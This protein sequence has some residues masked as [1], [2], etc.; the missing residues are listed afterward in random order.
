MSI[1]EKLNAV[2][3]TIPHYWPIGSFI[4]HN[5][6]KGF[7]NLHFKEALE[8]AQDV[9]GG[10]SYMAPEYYISHYNEGKIKPNTLEKNLLKALK[11]AHLE[12]FSSEAKTFMLEV[13]PLW[14]S[15]RSYEELK[16]NDIDEELHTYLEDNSIYS[17]K[18][19]WLDTL[20]H[21]M[22]FYEIH[23]ALFNTTEK[24]LI[25]KDV[26]EYIARFLD[27]NQTTLSMADRERGMFN[28]F[29]LYENINYAGNAESYVEIIL[30]KLKVKD[31]EKYL[32]THLL[33]LYGW[34]G[35]IK[36]RSEDP[37]YYSQQQHPSS[38]IDYIAVKLHFELKYIAGERIDDF[39]K[40]QA[41]IE[42]NYAFTILKLLQSKGRLTGTYNDAMEE[43]Q[44]Y[45]KILDAFV[46]DEINL[47]SL[48]IQLAKKMIPS[49]DMPLIEFSKFAMFIKNEEG[50][51]W[52]KSLED[53]YI[54][55]YV[56]DFTQTHTYNDNPIA[57]AI[58][59][60]DVRSE[61][62]RRKIEQI[63]AYTTFGAGG[64]LGLPINFVPFDKAHELAL[65]PAV[66]KPKNIVFEVPLEEHEEYNTKK[67]LN[68]TYKKVLNDLKNNPYT[69]YIMVEAIG[70]AFG[71]KLF[72]KTF[73]PQKTEKL[74]SKTKPIKPKTTFTLD[75]L[76]D[77]EIE[78][79]VKK[80]HINIIN[81]VLVTQSDAILNNPQ[82]ELL[83]E[84]LVLDKPLSVKVPINFIHSLKDAYHINK[85]DYEIQKEKLSHVGFTFEEQ[86]KYLETILKMMGYTKDFSKFII[87]VAHGSTSDNNPFESALDCGACGGNVS[88]P[89]TRAICM[90][91]NKTK[92]RE[93][94]KQRGINI[95][96]EVRFVP[97][98]HNTTTDEITYYDIY[99]FTNEEQKEFEKVKYDFQRASY[100]AR[101][102]RIKVL[103]N[104]NTQ[105]DI[106]V[107][108]MDWSD[109]RPEWGLSRN[110]GA[111]AGPRD[112]I[113]HLNLK[114]R[115]FMHSYDWKVDNDN[116]DL[117][118][119]IFDGPLIV[120]EWINLTHYFSTVD[121]SIYGAG[122]KVYHN[123]VAKIGVYN[124]NY[125]D[126]KI[127]LPT[128]SVI[129]EGEAYHEP[130]RLL[131]F[132]EAPLEKVGKA[133]ENSI[134]QPFILN[135]W[136]RPIIIDKGAKKVYAYEYGEFIVI[137]ELE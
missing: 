47:N 76:S 83:W 29:K 79:Y 94:L 32:L 131:T 19:M 113:K 28:T 86:V 97:A 92:I 124:G 119:R 3:D 6:L 98:L 40:L 16:I 84:H 20:T 70:W 58:F 43:H 64:F 2:K 45:E 135:E 62:M 104:T 85:E 44:E 25:E 53:S 130:V 123:I 101:E 116:A 71:L 51:I 23:D 126:L 56:D 117:L 121:N 30:E 17:N 21:N 105:E 5:P 36:Y 52:L 24:E 112:T 82:I 9:F 127:G 7:E 77:D 38:L 120:G 8:K 107:K 73:F 137:K 42:D 39:D 18:K 106:F 136:I 110:I 128:Q 68:K 37:D 15:L 63:G 89:N 111:F 95:P 33:K 99:N 41:F 31:I 22:T 103:P 12:T 96:Q 122:S 69:P 11:D 48:Q 108:A 65:A 49:L 55:D 125:S 132:M 35:F 67:S 75:V 134:A 60:L 4:A 93:I 115:I 80:L 114:N 74:F 10:K 14:E 13:S 54:E 50:Y 100:D 102:E 87:F 88:L 59:C 26:I 66:I 91:A 81:E 27:D 133:V 109:P 57:S 46:K 78:K 118:T 72:G 129:T 1:L 61:V 90:I 34:A